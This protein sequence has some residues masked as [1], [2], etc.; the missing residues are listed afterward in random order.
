MVSF[1]EP[2]RSF[3][4]FISIAVLILLIPL[5]V[6]IGIAIKLNDKGRVF[7]IQ[8]RIGKN[9]K[10]FRLYKFRSM[11]ELKAASNG[12]FEPGNVSRVTG[13]GKILRKTKM[14]EL[15][16]FINVLKGEMSLVG[17]R[18]EVRK[19]VEVYPERWSKILS[20]TPGITDNASIEFRNEEELLV[21]SECPEKTYKELIL[22][23]K[24]DLYEKYID[25]HSFTGDINL[26][27]KT[28]YCCIFK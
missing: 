18:P 28:V 27:I 21:K 20:I 14:D 1:L 22:P 11:S 5:F 9:G 12:Y 13:I 26:I 10:P 25:N 24:L 4:L 6:I 8:E 16:Q 19:W 15:P 7:F 3:D 2:K 17:P 23:H